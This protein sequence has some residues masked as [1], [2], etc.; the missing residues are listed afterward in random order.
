VKEMLSNPP[1]VN[2]DELRRH[3][4]WFVALG[5]A[6]IILG[7]IALAYDAFTT[8][9]SVL[10]F[11]WLLVIGGVV[12]IIHG[13]Q[14][15]RWGGFFLHLLAGL[16]FL[17]AGLLF[18]VNPLAGALSLTLFLGAFF[19]VGG[20]FEIIGAVRLRAPHWRW[21]VLGGVITAVLGLMLW[22]QWPGSGLWFIGFAVGISMIFRGWAWVMLGMMARGA[23]G[24]IG[25]THAA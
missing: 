23:G 13:F 12:E 14:T 25:K 16:L 8:I 4:G 22:A 3:S 9:A 11:G 7:V 1:L 15:H 24:V 6:L 17:V 20:V 2:S 21:A 10:V 19:L 5:I 18:V